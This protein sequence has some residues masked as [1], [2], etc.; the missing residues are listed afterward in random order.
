MVLSRESSS[1]RSQRSCGPGIVPS[2]NAVDVIIVVAA[3]A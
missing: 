2:P 1:L 3:P